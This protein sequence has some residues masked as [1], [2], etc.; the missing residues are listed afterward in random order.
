LIAGSLHPTPTGITTL[1][2][3][4]TAQD[5]II[6]LGTIACAGT[7][8]LRPLLG[9]TPVVGDTFTVISAGSVTGTFADVSF[10]GHPGAGIVKPLYRAGDVRVAV[11]GAVT[12]VGGDGGAA[13]P[14]ALRFAA[15]GAPR[16]TAL[17]LDLPG[18][19]TVRVAVFDVAGRQLATLADGELGAGRHRFELARVAPGSGMYFARAEVTDAHGTHAFATR[20]VVLR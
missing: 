2:L 15:E 5:A 10:D 7:L 11:I 13:L 18:P 6:A 19:A 3:G 8:D 12:A 14:A 17:A 1:K 20:A 16:A 9:D 4:H